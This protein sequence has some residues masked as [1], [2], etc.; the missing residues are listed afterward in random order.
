LIGLR[1]DYNNFYGFLFTPRIHIRYALN[2][3]ATIR[4]S[5]GKGY[6]TPN[7]LAENFPFL[8]SN[9]AFVIQESESDLPYGLKMEEAWNYGVNYTH[10]FLIDYREMVLA[11]DFYRTDF[12]N[13]L[14]V[15]P[16]LNPNEVNFYNLDGK[17]FANSFQIQVDY[18]L[19]KR[20]DFRA[21]Y[22]WYDVQMEYQSEGLTLAPLLPEHRAFINL[23]YYT[24]DLWA[25]DLTWNWRG[26]QLV[27]SKDLGVINSSPAFSVNAQI[28]K[29]VKE[30]FEYYIGVENLFNFRQDA[31]IVMS[32]NPNHKSFDA[33]L[34]WGPIFGRNI[35][36][37][38]RM[39]L[40]GHPKKKA[41]SH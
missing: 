9:R 21:A 16:F 36:F 4:A 15:D 14:V 8:A 19:I 34:V 18:E 20:F 3:N 41:L 33:T 31:P 35:Y 2:E 24:R 6:R 37:G 32:S 22:R 1:E 11:I 5:G 25:F 28:T 29:E 23:A 17:S 39:D 40:E 13:Q 7:V 30:N 10:K 12:Q 26:E 38:I 27:P